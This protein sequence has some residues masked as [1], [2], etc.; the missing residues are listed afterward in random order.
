M[1]LGKH[2]ATVRKERTALTGY[3]TALFTLE[4]HECGI[5][6]PT[7]KSLERIWGRLSSLPFDTK[8]MKRVTL[9]ETKALTSKRRAR[10]NQ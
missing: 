6:G 2:R 8:K 3:G 10:H 5:I 4:G 9:F 1:R 7:K